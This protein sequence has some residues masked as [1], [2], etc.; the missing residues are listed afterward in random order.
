MAGYS[1]PKL[2]ISESTFVLD[3]ESKTSSGGDLNY[4]L[5]DYSGGH[6]TNASGMDTMISS[7]TLVSTGLHEGP[8]SWGGGSQTWRMPKSGVVTG[9]VSGYPSYAVRRSYY[10]VLYKGWVY[11]S[12][13]GTYQ[14]SC[15]GDDAMDVTINGTIV[16]SWYGGHGFG[17]SASRVDGSI[18]L[19]K[20]WHSFEARFEEQGGGDGIAVGWKTPSGSWEIIPS[21][22][23]KPLISSISRLDIIPKFLKRGPIRS[24]FKN[25]K[26]RNLRAVQFDISSVIDLPDDMGYSTEVSVF[27]WYK[28]KGTPTGGYHIICGGS[29]LEISIPTSGALRVG[30]ETSTGRKVTNH[31]SGLTDGNWHHVGFT[32]DGLNKRAFIDGKYVGQQEVTGTLI[33]T[34][35][36]RKIGQFG[37][38]TTYYPNGEIGPYQVYKKALTDLEVNKLYNAHKKRYK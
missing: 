25:I 24:N 18:V 34:F 26:G 8:L 32:F 22:N 29:H 1:G 37:S 17:D 20:G 28:S 19:S 31:G 12:E 13:D 9:V 36:N 3:P 11:A 23:F 7:A 16:C 35:S 27:A 6:P 30:I 2:P 5:Y 38:S 14:F 10:A 15:D 4:W 21:S 33:N